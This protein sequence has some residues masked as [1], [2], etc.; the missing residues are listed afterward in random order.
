M[1]L[2]STMIPNDI[3]VGLIVFVVCA[4]VLFAGFGHLISRYWEGKAD[5]KEKDVDIARANARVAEA[6]T[7]GD[8]NLLRGHA[9]GLEVQPLR[10]PH[11]ND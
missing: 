10:Q 9:S 6:S 2:G 5:F 3:V 7:K 8:R 11:P 1:Q 4:V